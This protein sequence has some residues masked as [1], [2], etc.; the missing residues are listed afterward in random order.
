MQRSRYVGVALLLCTVCES[1][2]CAQSE[3]AP[4][5]S[6]Q[7]APEQ[8]GSATVTQ[9]Q[10][11]GEII[12]TARRRDERAIDV[13]IAITAIGSESLERKNIFTLEGVAAQTPQLVIGDTGGQTGAA[14]SLRGIGS[15]NLNVGG[16]QAVSINVDGIQVSQGNI[17]RLGQY[18]LARVEVLEGPQALFF[19][20]NSPAG[21]ISLVSADPTRTVEARVRAGYETEAA[22]K[23]GEAVISG[24]ISGDLL[25]RL[26]VYGSSQEGWFRNL[27]QPVAALGLTPSPRK[28]PG[29]DEIF[30]RLT[31][32]YSPEGSAFSARLKIAYSHLDD[33][34]GIQAGIQKY[35]CPA[36]ASLIAATPATSECRLDRFFEKS[37]ILPANAAL[38][39]RYRDGSPYFNAQQLLASL[40]LTHRLSDQ[41]SLTSISGFY[42]SREKN[43][44]VYTY[45]DIPYVFVASNVRNEQF[46][47]E[48]RLSS[49]FD[50]PINVLL[51]AYYQH[52]RIQ[53]QSPVGFNFGLVGVPLPSFVLLDPDF[54]VKTDSGSLFGQLIYDITD[55]LQLTGGA[56]VTRE[57]KALSG[58]FPDGAGGRGPV[59]SAR[60]TLTFSNLSP[61]ATLRF[62]PNANTTLYGS[63]RTGFISGGYDISAGSGSGPTV[64]TSFDQEKVRGGE[65]GAKA[66]L[67][68]RQLQFGFAAFSYRY[69]GLQLTAFDPTT[70]SVRTVNAGSATTR[71]IEANAILSPRALPG[72]SLN[73]AIAY[74]RARYGNTVVG[75]YPG[76][77]VNLGCNLEPVGGVFQTQQLRGQALTRAPDW[78]GNVGFTYE[79]TPA[80]EI[81]YGFS[82]DANYSSSYQTQLEN[83]PR[84]RQRSFWKLNATASLFGPDRRWQLSFI[85]KNLTNRL[86]IANT[87]PATLTGFGTGTSGPASL[88]D[89]GGYVM[90]P[91]TLTLQL[92][93][94]R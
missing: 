86:T 30:S 54:I 74:T 56:R 23:F 45:S 2:V 81:G 80:S 57:R 72:F 3:A 52:Q 41:F 94:R 82:S 61:E 92:T 64:D 14:I 50:G 48:L 5:A 40:D 88:S 78:T 9:A 76:Q 8:P 20:K 24:P 70:I 27:A 84:A 60:P 53:N 26:D 49:S 13:P 28:A 43:A 25:G 67:F 39:P 10:G 29:V 79:Q 34:S 32:K 89:L 19:G 75:C 93:L 42:R 65:I 22:Q 17:A 37:N 68:D 36:G 31:L 6:G 83:D 55:Q 18:D 44:D 38:D 35:A 11:S 7:A 73:G 51:G 66:L 87:F 1:A 63:Y 58:T 85:G 59:Q 46:T 90:A 69:T 62:K 47:E 77:T 91:R 21:V 12:V 16:D 71:G 15:S 4:A 33:D